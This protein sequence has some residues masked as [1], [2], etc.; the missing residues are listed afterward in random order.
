MKKDILIDLDEKFS[1]STINESVAVPGQ[2]PDEVIARIDL[3]EKFSYGQYEVDQMTTTEVLQEYNTQLTSQINSLPDLDAILQEWSWRCDKGFPV[4]GSSK[5]MKVLLE[6]LNENNIKGSI[7][8]SINSYITA[9]E[10]KF[11]KNSLTET[12]FDPA[13]LNKPKYFQGFIDK[14]QSGEPFILE[15]DRSKNVTIDKSFLETLKSLEKI[16][17]LNT[18]QV[19]MR[20]L[21]GT[22]PIIPLTDGQVIKLSDISKD[23]FTAK[24]TKSGLAGTETPDFKEGLVVFFYSCPQSQLTEI[25]ERVINNTPIKSNLRTEINAINAAYYGS[26]SAQFVKTGIELLTTASALDSKTKNLYLNALSAA[27]TIQDQFGTGLV[28][29]R[30]TLFETI[31]TTASEI[32]KIAKDKWCPG[33]VYLYNKSAVNSIK[34]IIN[35]SKTNNAIVNIEDKSGKVLQ[36]GLNSLFDIDNPL[37]TAVSLKEQEAVSGRAKEFL[38]VK[39]ITGQQ[40]GSAESDFTKEELQILKAFAPITKEVIDLYTN[41]YETSKNKYKLSVRK[42]GYKNEF[43]SS[44]VTKELDKEALTRNVIVKTAVYRLLTKYFETFDELKSI[45]DIMKKYKDPFLALTAFGVSLSGFNPTFYKVMASS[46]GTLGH[47]TEFKGRDSLKAL[48]DS[49]LTIDTPTKAGIYLEFITKMGNKK[50]KTKLDVRESKGG[51]SMS[52]AIIVDEFKEQ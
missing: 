15:K 34:K 5:D 38:S 49:V 6:V 40:L 37:V 45:N 36:T 10:V 31:R 30:G 7:V 14:I 50:Y 47:V 48:T 17:D 9:E 39:N 21:F 4:W 22:K 33:D 29:D 11:N 20:E 25:Q 51:S 46:N 32:T 35:E 41:Q 28:I 27:R 19:K 12:S 44:K 13:N 43:G 1:K 23:T 52:I 24:T 16:K 26:K 3:V 8:E 42:F 18:R 2:V